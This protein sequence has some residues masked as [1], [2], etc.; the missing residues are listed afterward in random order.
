[1][2]TSESCWGGGL[3]VLAR[4]EFLI[5]GWAGGGDWVDIGWRA[6]GG[7][8]AGSGLFSGSSVSRG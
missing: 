1:M 3:V 7:C 4:L 5:W 8:G 2:V 6:A